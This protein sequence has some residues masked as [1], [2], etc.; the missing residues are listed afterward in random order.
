MTVKTRLKLDHWF[1]S[2]EPVKYPLSRPLGAAN[3]CILPSM[4][5]VVPAWM[6]LIF[7]S[8]Y[9]ILLS[10]LDPP[11]LFLCKGTMKMHL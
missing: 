6:S 9:I 11:C 3:F 8:S 5:L 7:N 2:Y 4:H 10:I 1:K